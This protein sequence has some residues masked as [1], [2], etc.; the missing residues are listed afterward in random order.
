MTTAISNSVA[1]VTPRAWP[2]RFLFPAFLVIYFIVG[3]GRM[4][5][6]EW[7]PIA[8]WAMF[9]TVPNEVTTYRL[10][11]T[12]IGTRPISPPAYYGKAEGVFTSPV[13]I[14]SVSAIY[15]LGKSLQTHDDRVT[16]QYRKLVERSLLP[17]QASYEIVEQRYWPIEKWL[18][19]R[20]DE[21]VVAGFHTGSGEE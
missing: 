10:R 11:V 14:S 5:K 6:S 1:P 18:H 3:L 7:Y 20:Y 13:R 16:V 21:T 17:P 9:S 19:N 15:R 12:S 8:S 2:M 4:G